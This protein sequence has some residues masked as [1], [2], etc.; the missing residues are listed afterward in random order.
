M[1]HC[2]GITDDVNPPSPLP[3]SHTHTHNTHSKFSSLLSSFPVVE[4]V[5]HNC[6]TRVL[7]LS[8]RCP[9]AGG[10]N[11][12]VLLHARDYMLHAVGDW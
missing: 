5:E 9:G 4:E 7:S 8:S 2:A 10:G 11:F 1:L 6:A 12:N 3:P